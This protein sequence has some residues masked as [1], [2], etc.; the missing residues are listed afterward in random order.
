MNQSIIQQKAYG[1][2][3]RNEL[4]VQLIDKDVSQAEIARRFK[5]TRQCINAI[6]KRRRKRNA[7]TNICGS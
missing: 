5:V 3:E 7:N 6:V 1:T 4:I 2:L